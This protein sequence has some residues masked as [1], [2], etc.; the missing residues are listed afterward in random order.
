MR[1]KNMSLSG[2]VWS[3]LTRENNKLTSVVCANWSRQVLTSP[4]FSSHAPDLCTS[5][6]LPPS[7]SDRVK[8]RR[9]APENIQKC[10]LMSFLASFRSPCIHKAE[11]GEQIRW[12]VGQGAERRADTWISASRL[13]SETSTVFITKGQRNISGTGERR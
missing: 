8:V 7:P 12:Y 4:N 2:H 6:G 13:A 3:L 10:I 1:R 5:P 9:N 11:W